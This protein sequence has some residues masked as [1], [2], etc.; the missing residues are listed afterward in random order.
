MDVS[1]GSTGP[2]L[3]GALLPI[4]FIVVLGYVDWLA[5]RNIPVVVIGGVVAIG[6]ALFRSQISS[7]LLRIPAIA[8]IPEP[9]RTIGLAAIPL[10]YFSL[11]GR[12]T[13]GAGGLV[14]V[15]GLA[16]VVAIQLFGP[17]L[18]RS[19][20]RFYEARNRVLPR[21]LRM[22]LVPLVAIVVTFLLIHGSL[23][24]LPAMFGGT[25]RAPASPAGRQGLFLVGVLLSAAAGIL[26]LRE[27]P[28]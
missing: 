9:V 4:I 24:D 11:R 23:G 15:V 14:L 13:S 18:D 16:V 25:T 7:R 2:D 22:L 27:A 8:R 21:W 17:A 10:L 26:L 1:R 12:G 5:H 19:L 20:A 6:L 3:R 28:E